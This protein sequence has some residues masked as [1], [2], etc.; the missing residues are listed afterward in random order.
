MKIRPKRHHKSTLNPVKNLQQRND[1]RTDTEVKNFVHVHV[2]CAI[3]EMCTKIN[4]V[5]TCMMLPIS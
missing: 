5:L 1:V 4:V 2:H 3:V